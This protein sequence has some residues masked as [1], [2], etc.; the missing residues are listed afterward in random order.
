MTHKKI[1]HLD[2]LLFDNRFVRE[3]PAD[4]QTHNRPREV[5]GACYSWVDPNKVSQAQSVAVSKEVADLLDL[6]HELCTSAD[7]IDVFTGNRLAKGMQPYATCYGGHQFG[8]RDDARGQRDFFTG[9]TV[10]IA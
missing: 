6:S 8:D 7:F 4:I 3:L 1:T 2:Q 10:R 5:L 9:Q